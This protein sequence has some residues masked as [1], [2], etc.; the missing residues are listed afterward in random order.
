MYALALLLTAWF[1][2]AGA[3][4]E[5]VPVRF[6]DSLY[7]AKFV[8]STTGWAVGAFGTIMATRDGGQTWRRQASRTTEPLFGVD[9]A[10][11]QRGWVVGRSGLI[12]A[13]VDGGV[14]WAA[15]AS[16]VDRHLFKVH[17]ADAH[18]G[19]AV[20]DW[21]TIVVTRNGGATWDT[22]SLSRD[23]I[24]NDV[25]LLDPRRG[26]I[27]GEAGTVV[28]TED[29][30]ET[31][32]ER[33]SGVA[34][35]LFGVDF[36]DDQRGW[37]VGIDALILRTA[38]AGRTW[39]VQNGSVEVGALEQVAFDAASQTPS[40]YEVRVLGSFG[41]A[42]GESGAIF[43]S[44][45][46]GASWARQRV[47]QDWGLSWLRDIALTAGP[48]GVIVGADGRR[49]LIHNG[50]IDVPDEQADAAKTVH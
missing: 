37:A 15:Q 34:K 29:G 26:W 48:D 4:A 21:G 12:L 38:D 25:F 47:P 36:I 43:T 5:P 18:L 27:V 23:V 42:V 22:R 28:A 40:L 17:F 39:Q 6:S 7:A 20:G 30:G 24:L 3:A 44:A 2:G 10:D 16:G 32:S 14:T 46:G 50:R 45:D 31:W 33:N 13:T 35:T 49:V 9:F 11:A 1:G 41:A 19:C 8:D